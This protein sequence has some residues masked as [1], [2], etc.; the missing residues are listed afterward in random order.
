MD[1]RPAAGY[2]QGAILARPQERLMS[3]PDDFQALMARVR[4]GDERAAAELVSRYEPLIRREVRLRLEDRR[5]ARAFDSVD[6]CQSVLASFFV[7][8]AAGQYDLDQP[9]QLAA[10]LV[11]MAR[12]KVASAARHQN[13]QRRDQRRGAGDGADLEQFTG[14]GPT[15]SRVAIGKE[16]LANFFERLTD[17]ERQIA[18]LRAGGLGWEEV[19][20]QLGGTATARRMQLTRAAKRVV[21]E[22]GLDEGAPD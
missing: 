15:P 2:K 14:G 20:A 1:R 21:R 13:R 8:A 16:L 18:D 9:G 5:L 6:L 19:A 10:L 22:L 3:A 4:G 12:N 7:R 17:E 11:K